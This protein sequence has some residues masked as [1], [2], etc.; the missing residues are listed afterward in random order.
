M[1]VPGLL[2]QSTKTTTNT[3]RRFT[4]RDFT[5]GLMYELTEEKRAVDRL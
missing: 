5:E 4:V 1:G 2:I 3:V